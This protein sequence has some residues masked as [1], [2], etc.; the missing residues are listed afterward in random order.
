MECCSSLKSQMSLYEWKG[1]VNHVQLGLKQLITLHTPSC[2]ESM[3][4]DMRMTALAQLPFNYLNV[5]LLWCS[6]AYREKG[7]LRRKGGLQLWNPVMEH[8]EGKEG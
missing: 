6:G 3:G 4:L 5:P 8:T 2:L 1:R 7:N